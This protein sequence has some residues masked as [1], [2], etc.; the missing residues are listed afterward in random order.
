MTKM[1]RLNTTTRLSLGM[2]SVM[3]GFAVSPAS[4]SEISHWSFN[5]IEE[6]GWVADQTGYA[7]AK[8]SGMN[9]AELLVP[10]LF[11]DAISFEGPGLSLVVEPDLAPDLGDDFTIYCVIKPSRVGSYRTI[12]W[13]GARGVDPDQINYYAGIRDGKIEF[14]AMDAT[15]AWLV[16]TTSKVLHEDVW[17][18][19]YIHFKDGEVRIVLNGEEMS[20]SGQ[21][22]GNELPQ[23]LRNDWPMHIGEGAR[24]DGAPAFGFQGLIDEITIF[25][26][27]AIDASREARTRWQEALADYTLKLQ[28]YNAELAAQEQVRENELDAYYRE[29]FD[30][31]V[32]SADAPFY[33]VSIPTSTRID[34]R[35]NFIETIAEVELGDV[36]ISAAGSEYEGFQVLVVGNPDF[37]SED[38]YVEVSDFYDA[39]GNTLSS[40]SF[41]W[42]WIKS[43]TTEAPDIAVD[44]VGAIPDAIIEEEW[45]FQVKAGDFTPVYIRLYIEPG[46]PPGEY[47]GVVTVGSEGF[48]DEI[49]VTVNVFGFTLPVK[50]SL[51]VAFSFFEHFY[52]DWYGLGELSDAQKMRIYDF[53]L[54]Y[55]IAP[56]NIY[57]R[58]PMEPEPG[59]LEELKDR[60]N[61][62]T[63]K[64]WGGDVLEGDALRKQIEEYDSLI[65]TAEDMGMMDE[66][67][68]YGAD[69]LSHHMKRSLPAARQAVEMLSERYPELKMMQTSFPIP[70]LR[71]LYNVWVP[72]FHYFVDDDDLAVLEELREDGCEIWWYA[73]DDPHHP[74]PNFFLD[75]PVFDNRIIMTLSYMYDIDGILYWSIN[76]EWETNMD[77]R[78]A[79]PDAEWRPYIYSISTGKR[80]WRNGMG[81]FL[82]PAPDGDIYPSL[83]LE[84][85]RDGL[86]DYEY[87]VMLRALI[88]DLEESG[89]DDELLE[90]AKSLSAVP[91]NVAT[92][93]N[94]YNADPQALL[95]YRQSVGKMIERI[96]SKYPSFAHE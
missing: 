31:R 17:Y 94:S 64:G 59:L 84:N 87:L 69:E 81:N 63:I 12:L 45:D 60:T 2:A 67:Y 28:E 53:L 62:F 4:G 37:G 85:L 34:K 38:V 23:L 32:A 75:Y 86:E 15:G 70:E 80:K 6:G 51:P 9:N 14:K 52:A 61:F 20:V 55:R 7:D 93:I 79:W 71:G 41:Q 43:I 88:D 95:N 92:A 26:G 50:G 65:Q 33:L 76:R 48:S 21:A 44:F 96:L 68:F 25:Q 35:A 82:Y 11:G 13:K 30:Q 74:M 78:D 66:L 1:K 24:S 8:L 77:I 10:G 83:R 18:E 89:S 42:G 36:E 19:I 72:I 90:A 29:V 46:T 54:R 27:N 57:T 91:A 39:E 16:Y 56:N 3:L 58:K 40:D 73:A 5:A 22:T 49:P 47:R